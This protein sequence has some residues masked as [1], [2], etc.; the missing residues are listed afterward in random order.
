MHI[1]RS[2]LVEGVRK[3]FPDVDKFE[4]E[5]PNSNGAHKCRSSENIHSKVIKLFYLTSAIFFVSLH[6]L[7]FI[8]RSRIVLQS[9][10]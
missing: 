1:L 9:V 10:R 7:I 4:S 8:D 3:S 6:D 5:Y 2:E